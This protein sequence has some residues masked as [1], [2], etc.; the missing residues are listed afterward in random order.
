MSG[1]EDAVMLIL[2]NIQKD[3]A[4]L[5]QGLADVRADV[6]E[7]SDHLESFEGYFTYQ[8]GL[9]SRNTL[10]IKRL[11]GIRALRERVDDL[12]PQT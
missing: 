11:H 9:T 10:D 5:K 1:A 4:E 8:M 2:R 12:E 6:R 3:L 7:L